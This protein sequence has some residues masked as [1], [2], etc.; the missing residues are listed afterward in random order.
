MDRRR[1][2]V[3]EGVKKAI[4][5]QV[6]AWNRGDLPAF[7]GLYAEDATFVSP[8]GVARGR[9][10]VL[11]RYLKKYPD[12]TAMGTLLL[13]IAEVRLAEGD[14]VSLFGDTVPSR[15]HG[16]SVVGRWTLSWPDRPAASGQT[17]LVLRPRSETWE[18]V[19]DASM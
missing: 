13:E 7:V 16:V 3:A 17:L 2:E 12:R 15:V 10:Q 19:Q 11:E 8:S 5:A 18:I 14:E 6:E 1:S 9:D 4:A